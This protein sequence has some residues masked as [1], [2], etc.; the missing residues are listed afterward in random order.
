MHTYY[1]ILRVS[2]QATEQQIKAAFKRLA[3]K[4]HPDKNPDNAQAEDRFKEV[5]EAYQVLSDP[6]KKFMYD[7]R[8]YAIKQMGRSTVGGHTGGASGAR[9]RRQSSYM[10]QSRHMRSQWREARDHYQPHSTRT[11]ESTGG[12]SVRAA[13]NAR[14]DQSRGIIGAISIIGVIAL[15]FT[16]GLSAFT[17]VERMEESAMRNEQ[18]KFI[19]LL[20][21]HHD[22]DSLRSTLAIIDRRIEESSSF[23]PILSDFRASVVEI[24]KDDAIKL[25]KQG[26]YEA[27]LKYLELWKERFPDDKDW[28]DPQLVECH[29]AMEEFGKA[30]RLLKEIQGRNKSHLFVYTTLGKIYR[31]QKEDLENALFYYNKA[32]QF[33]I[34]DYKEE[35]GDAY[36]IMMDPKLTPDIQYEIFLN[37]AI[38]S[39]DLGF[40]EQARNA[41]NWASVL[42]PEWLEPWVYRG[43]AN[44]ALR[45]WGKACNSWRQATEVGHVVLLDSLIKYCQPR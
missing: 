27:S 36:A 13:F 44:Q 26:N 1:H 40:Y 14:K 4:Y 21:K 19:S 37:K 9:M 5:N 22:A 3:V 35:F 8:L 12:P 31:E 23:N 33:V 20:R 15:L 38:L 45:D 11:G 7:Q 43:R 6:Q 41:A 42:R 30:E 18:A 24:M 34:K 32:S 39:Y 2:E 25:F 10:R 17:L 16:I 28:L 29:L